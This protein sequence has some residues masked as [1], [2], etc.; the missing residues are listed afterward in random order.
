MILGSLDQLNGNL[1]AGW[2]GAKNEAI[3]PF[4][5]ANGRA[6]KLLD[7]GI[8]RAD[9][10]SITGLQPDV[11]YV[12]ELPCNSGTTVNLKLY[13]ILASGKIQFIKEQTFTFTAPLA[14]EKK[15]REKHNLSTKNEKHNKLCNLILLWKQHDAGIYG[16]R[17]DQVARSLTKL[18]ENCNIILLEIMTHQQLEGYQKEFNNTYSDKKYIIEDFLEKK[19]GK[20]SHG[21]N[22]KVLYIEDKKDLE[23]EF[24]NF[25]QT[26]NIH[27]ENSLFILFP[28]LVEF[29]KI[30][31]L[32][33]PYNFICDVVDNQI[34]WEEKNPFP[35]LQQYA[36][37]CSNATAVIFNSQINQR[38]F[39]ENNLCNAVKAELIPNWYKVP[40]G[41]DQ[42][43]T[44]KNKS[45]V[46][47]LYSGNMND[48]IDWEL[49]E[50]IHDQ[51]SNNAIIHLIGNA[52]AASIKIVE[53]MAKRERIIYHGPMR[54][55]E[56][57][58]FA[59]HCDLAIMPHLHDN[60]SHYMNPLKLHMYA[61]IRLPCIS[62]D[63]PGILQKSPYLW[64]CKNHDDFIFQLDKLIKKPR[65]KYFSFEFNKFKF[66][67]KYLQLI[68]R[69]GS[70]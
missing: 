46:D 27:P 43:H 44:P 32:L 5:T 20:I 57:L 1:I 30:S 61:A 53:L 42:K 26:E 11:G 19:T 45:H 3:E 59:K 22:H 66:E 64:L 58:E 40:L 6:C 23:K 39:V 34:S 17:V 21:V 24:T 41:D 15:A 50:K 28:I 70:L 67:K 65:F 68:K 2:L 37:L 55:N 33:A 54:E 52:E 69:I 38:F 49:I 62:I 14:C 63:V 35:L 31:E 36:N 47:I 10:A 51:C 48:R 8:S 29:Q 16:R 25:L 12:A 7:Y 13:A 9:V 18:S 56:L 4:L 60:H